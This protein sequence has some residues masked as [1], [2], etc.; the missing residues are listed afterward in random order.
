MNT[1]LINKLGDEKA[2]QLT[3]T[4]SSPNV[5]IGDPALLGTLIKQPSLLESGYLYPLP[6]LIYQLA[7]FHSQQPSPKQ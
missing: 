7:A 1:P 4:P 5:F 6:Y 3:S 2:K